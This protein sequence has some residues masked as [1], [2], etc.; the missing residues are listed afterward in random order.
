MTFGM[1]AHSVIDGS[2]PRPFAIYGSLAVAVLFGATSLAGLLIPS[3]YSRE[4]DNWAVQAI[5]QDWFD[6]VI[7]A[8]C[9][10]VAAIWA[11]RGSLRGKLVLGGALLYAV[12]T[13]LVY[14]LAIHLNVL[15]LFYCATLG[16]A[17]YSLIALALSVSPANVRAAFEQGAPRRSVGGFLVFIGVAFAGLWLSQLV[18]AALTGEPPLALVATGLFTNPVHV[19]DLSFVIPLHLIAGIGLW[20]GRAVGFVVA[21]V[22]LALDVLMMGTIGFLAAVME[23]RGVAEG[24]VPIVIAMFVVATLSLALLVWMLSTTRSTKPR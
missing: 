11:G 8:P 7:A 3:L 2:E 1:Q 15:F 10:F 13:L 5:A 22:L 17:L 9:I 18:P 20:R 6:L 19:I 12:Y 21:P 4:T 23:A 16:L 14:A 24:G